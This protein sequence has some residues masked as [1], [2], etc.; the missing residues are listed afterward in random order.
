MCSLVCVYGCSCV[1]GGGSTE[2]RDSQKKRSLCARALVLAHT[3]H[4]SLCVAL[5]RQRGFN[6]TGPSIW[7]Q[8]GSVRANRGSQN[9]RGAVSWSADLLPTKRSLNRTEQNTF[10]KAKDTKVQDSTTQRA[11]GIPPGLWVSICSGV[12][13]TVTKCNDC[14]SFWCIWTFSLTDVTA[15]HL[16]Y[17]WKHISVIFMWWFRL[18]GSST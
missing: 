3:P 12:S 13:F 17:F 1:R 16:I 6:Q 18:T 9:K 15:F 14:V 8:R 2:G 10:E 5:A 7:Y 11:W 4:P